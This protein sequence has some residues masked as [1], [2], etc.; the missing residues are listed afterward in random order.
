MFTRL[1]VFM[2]ALDD[3]VMQSVLKA[4]KFEMDGHQC[5]EQL[6]CNFLG[7]LRIYDTFGKG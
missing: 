6:V 7:F 4:G 3:L 2:C 5:S 1:F